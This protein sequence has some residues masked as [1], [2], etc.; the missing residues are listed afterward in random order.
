[1][2]NV[3][4]KNTETALKMCFYTVDQMTDE[5]RLNLK[6]TVAS[7]RKKGAVV[8]KLVALYNEDTHKSYIDKH[9]FN[10]A[11]LRVKEDQPVEEVLNLLLPDDISAF[12]SYIFT[13]LKSRI[14]KNIRE[15]WN[16]TVEEPVEEEENGEMEQVEALVDAI[17]GTSIRDTNGVVDAIVACQTIQEE[18]DESSDDMEDMLTELTEAISN[19]EP[20]MYI[21]NI[22]ENDGSVEEDTEIESDN[23][24]P[25]ETETEEGQTEFSVEESLCDVEYDHWQEPVSETD[26]NSTTELSYVTPDMIAEGKEFI[27]TKQTIKYDKHFMNNEGHIKLF[28][29]K[30][31]N[32]Y[33]MT[34]PTSEHVYIQTAFH[35][36][37]NHSKG[38]Y[39]TLNNF[40]SDRL[41]SVILYEDDANCHRQQTLFMSTLEGLA[42]HSDIYKTLKAFYPEAEIVMYTKARYVNNYVNKEKPKYVFNTV[43]FFYGEDLKQNANW[44]GERFWYYEYPGDEYK[45][46]TASQLMDELKNELGENEYNASSIRPVSASLRSLVYNEANIRAEKDELVEEMTRRIEEEVRAKYDTSIFI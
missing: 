11:G 29:D 20:P 3:Y 7:T 13:E 42:S 46:F 18:T 38:V 23:E 39:I 5:E 40:G 8:E 37:D 1:M 36:N 43:T 26:W 16:S 22:T 9:F 25:E 28:T 21:E 32:E 34:G 12:E 44:N 2:E 35:I 30:V 45:D 15:E 31:P 24:E 41:M 4:L 6:T 19:D 14:R 10:S 33:N 27:P 17:N